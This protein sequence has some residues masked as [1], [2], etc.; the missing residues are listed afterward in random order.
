MRSPN[1]KPLALVCGAGPGVGAAVTSAFYGADYQVVGFNRSEHRAMPEGPMF[2]QLD[3]S[4]PATTQE[5]IESI[6]AEYGAPRVYVHNP[7]HLVIEPFLET[8]VDQ[9]EAAWRSMVLSAFVMLQ[10]I[11]P[12]M[13]EQGQGTII[14]S[15]AT[16]ST[17]GGARFSAFASAKFALR[18]LI[19]SVAREYQSQGIHAV[20]VLLDGI[21]DTPRSRELHAMDPQKM[22]SAEDVAQLYV[23]LAHQPTSI[24]THE[25]DLRPQSEKF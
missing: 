13:V 11:V 9:Y 19:Q 1:Q 5:M 23:D 2:R 22:I 25:L 14:V 12:L 18:G 10:H 20:H 24:W 16:A 7:A 8:S 15:G 21:V 17:K 6:V 4:D 3:C